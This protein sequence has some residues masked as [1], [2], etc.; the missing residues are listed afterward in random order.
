MRLSPLWTLR[1]SPCPPTMDCAGQSPAPSTRYGWILILAIGA[2]GCGGGGGATSKPPT[3]PTCTPVATTEATCS[4]GV[5]DDCDGYSTASTPSATGSRAAT[6]LTCSGGACR[7]PCPPGVDLRPR[8]AGHPERPRHHPRRHRDHR[9]RAGGRRGR[10]SHLPGAGSG[11][12]ADRRERRGRCSQRHLPL[13]RRSRVPGPRGRRRQ[14]LRLLDRGLRQHPPRLRPHGGRI[15][16]RL[17]LPD[18]RPPIA[19]PVYRVAN[20]NGGGGFRNA[21]WVV[22]IYREA[23]SA[24]YVTDT[25]DARRAAG[26]GLARRRHRLLHAPK[27]RGHETVYRIQYAP[28]ADWQGDNVV[29]FF[30]DGPEHDAR[31]A[32]PAAEIADLGPRF[33]ILDTQA[34]G[35][36][37][38]HR[39]M[40]PGSF[41]VL[42]AG[43]AR[44]DQVLHQGGRPLWSLDLARASSSPRASSSRRSTQVARS[45]TATSL[46]RTTTPTSTGRACSPSTRRRSRSTRRA[47]RPAR[48]SST[49]STTRTTGPRPIARAYV[50]VTPAAA[51]HDGLPRDLRRGRR[52]GAVHASGRTTTASSIRNSK[53]AV[54]TSGCTENF[55]FGPVLGQLC[56]GSPTAARAA[57]SASRRKNV[58]DE[59]RGRPLPARAHVVGHPVDRPALPADHD[60]Q[61]RR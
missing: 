9:L 31:A 54:D 60:H 22:P 37:A 27:R 16:P 46:P 39:V 30:T 56:S 5:D 49:A 15:D 41:D 26:E 3:G 7:A 20:P 6:G 13:R 28:G 1:G 21:D 52:L 32:Q 38:L 40:Y 4:G 43:E 47:S 10:L 34:P 35:S 25:A 2:A 59:A 11:R 23:N 57:T 61:R 8:A 12:L 24:E 36:V 50:D 51:P 33:S 58:A 55:T 29:F 14:P 45:R 17:R 19:L 42:A 44:F 53:W 48:C 18:A